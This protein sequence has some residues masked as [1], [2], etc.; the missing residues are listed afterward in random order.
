MSARLRAT[1][2]ELAVLLWR[3]H[4][5]YRERSG[6][7][8]I[9]GDHVQRWISLAPTGGQG[10]LLVRAGR[11]LP[12]GTTAPARCEAVADPAAGTAGLAALCRRLLA[13]TAAPEDPATVPRQRG[14]H[15]PA[16]RSR[17]RTR[18]PRTARRRG[19]HTGAASWAVLLCVTGLVAV[20]VYL[21]AAGRG[22]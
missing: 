18:T 10:E 4:T 16:P 6:G 2:A 14:A 21:A 17:T 15:D 12:G 19:R 3:E 13:E 9:R 7:V 20:Y 5:V 8:V 1:A 22:I 11:I